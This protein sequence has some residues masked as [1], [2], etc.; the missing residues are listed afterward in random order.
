MTQ[1]K[2]YNTLSGK[3]E[4]FQPI[5]D[6]VRIYSCGPTVY[7]YAHIGNLRTYIFMDLL[8]RVLRYDG[9][10]VKNVMNITDVGHLLSDADEGEDK[11]ERSARERN[12]DPYEI[13]R[14][15]TE[16]FFRDTD[17]LNIVRP[18]VTPRATDNIREMIDIVSALCEKGYAYE[19][20]D[21][22]YYDVSKFPDYGKL[23]GNIL[24]E[25][26]AG[27]RV[28]VNDQKRHPADFAL[29]KKLSPITSCSGT[30]P[31]AEA[32]PDGTSNVRL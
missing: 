18:T 14:E 20:D 32:S 29:W 2:V 23:S 5:N 11:M 19:I 7:K 24:E 12:T 1:L 21:G 17:S 10:K 4:V 25:Q 15:V 30:V 28:E 3:K 26:Q 8:V 16:R 9:Y 13:A 27:A 6:L 31:G 22:I